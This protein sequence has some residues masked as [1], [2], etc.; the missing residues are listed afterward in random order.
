VG[1]GGGGCGRPCSILAWRRFLGA[2]WSKELV[3][4]R[5]STLFRLHVLFTHPIMHL[6]WGR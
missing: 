2:K 3:G 1:E 6:L 4:R 5:P